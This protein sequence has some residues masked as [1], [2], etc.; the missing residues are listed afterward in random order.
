MPQAKKAA[1]PATPATATAPTAGLAQPQGMAGVPPPR[2]GVNVAEELVVTGLANNFIGKVVSLSY[3][4]RKQQKGAKANTYTLFVEL[5]IQSED[6]SVGKNGIVVE[7]Y[8]CGNLNQWVPSSTEPVWDGNNWTYAPSGGTVDDY[9]QLH[10]GESGFEVEGSPGELAVMPPDNFRG[11]YVIP[12]KQNSQTNLPKGTKWSRMLDE[13]T[14]LGYTPTKFPGVAFHDF[15]SFLIGTVAMWVRLPFEFKGGGKPL[16]ME[17][18][19]RG[20]EVLLPTE[21]YTWGTGGAPGV[22]AVAPPTTP[23]P[24]VRPATAPAQAPTTA[25]AAAP[26]AGLEATVNEI[27]TGYAVN[28]GEAGISKNDISNTL[29]KEL[30]ARGLGA[31]AA[32]GLVLLN[33]SDWMIGDERTFAYDAAAG[34]LYPLT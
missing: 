19:Q 25:P 22:A 32:R 5:V 9:M 29:F 21:V 34:M 13:L 4:P 2:F 33:N 30:Q 14:T 15:R 31:A 12:G 23:A 11:H 27:L 16:E 3:L 20:P 24:A 6:Q 26:A 10:L 7:Y 8:G 1:A 28:A 17:P 18:G